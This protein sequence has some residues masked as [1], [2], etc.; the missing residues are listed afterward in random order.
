VPAAVD[1]KQR[2]VGQKRKRQVRTDVTNL[3]AYRQTL[4]CIGN[5]CVVCGYKVLV[6]RGSTMVANQRPEMCWRHG[7][8]PEGVAPSSLL[9]CSQLIGV[10]SFD[11]PC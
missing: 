2:T 4:S 5:G 9:P 3:Y 7:W 11:L 1:Q 10:L 8:K 6:H